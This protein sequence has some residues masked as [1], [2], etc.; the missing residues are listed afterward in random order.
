MTLVLLI[1]VKGIQKERGREK[2]RVYVA[3]TR[4]V[5][6]S[7]SSIKISLFSTVLVFDFARSSKIGTI[8]HKLAGLY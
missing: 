8:N 7:L 5:P 1:S 2:E 4:V 3:R 6:D